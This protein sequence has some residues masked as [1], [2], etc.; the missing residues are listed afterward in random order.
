MYPPCGHIVVF[1][2][3]H[4]LPSEFMMLPQCEAMNMQ[5]SSS[6]KHIGLCA[7][8]FSLAFCKDLQCDSVDSIHFI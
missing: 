4:V 5:A 2:F 8:L 6:A 7:E 3:I 1:D